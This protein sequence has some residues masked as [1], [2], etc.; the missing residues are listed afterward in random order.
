MVSAGEYQNH[1]QHLQSLPLDG[2]HY[3]GHLTHLAHQSDHQYNI[4]PHTIHAVHTGVLTQAGPLAQVSGLVHAPPLNQL[5]AAHLIHMAPT[6]QIP[7]SP[8]VHEILPQVKK[9]T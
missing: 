1:V 9:N 6:A 2:S 4:I 8:Y 5:N 3:H 7:I